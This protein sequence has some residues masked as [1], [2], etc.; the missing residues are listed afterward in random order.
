MRASKAVVR[1]F[2]PL[3]STWSANIHRL[4][5][6]RPRSE[7][8]QRPTPDWTAAAAFAFSDIRSALQKLSF[9][10][11]PRPHASLPIEGR[12]RS[13]AKGFILSPLNDDCDGAWCEGANGLAHGLPAAKRG[14]SSN[15]ALFGQLVDGQGLDG[16]GL[17]GRGCTLAHFPAVPQD[18]PPEKIIGDGVERFLQRILADGGVENEDM[19]DEEQEQVSAVLIPSHAAGQAIG[20]SPGEEERALHQH[21]EEHAGNA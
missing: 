11:D 4:R 16:Q 3:T 10:A 17:E 13:T 9:T 7:A 18:D 8:R 12:F 19:E 21:P 14:P 20:S 6:R 1:K 5:A 2:I 15:C